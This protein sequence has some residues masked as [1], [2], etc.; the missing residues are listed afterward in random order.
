M[1]TYSYRCVQCNMT[2]DRMHR[3][4]ETPLIKCPL[5][6]QRMEKLIG[7]GLPPIIKG[8]QNKYKGK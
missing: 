2:V 4:Y 5:C 1:P 3:H 8:T 6:N 7:G